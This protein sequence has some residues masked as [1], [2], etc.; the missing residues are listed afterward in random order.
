MTLPQPLIVCEQER[1][2]AKAILA[3][4]TCEDRFLVTRRDFPNRFLKTWQ[5]AR[6][7]HGNVM[8]RQ[9]QFD[10][11]GELDQSVYRPGIGG[12]ICLGCEQVNGTQVE[13]IAGEKQPVLAIQETERIGSVTGSE[14]DLEI[15]AT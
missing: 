13:S 15:T 3:M 7:R 14:D 4:V 9:E 10:V 6:T 8:T 2:A 11:R 1:K 12:K 5:V